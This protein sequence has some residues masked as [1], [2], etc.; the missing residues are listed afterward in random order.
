MDCEYSNTLNQKTK[1]TNML[2][3]EKFYK[4]INDN[5]SL[6]SHG[7]K[8]KYLKSLLGHGLKTI[9]D[10]NEESLWDLTLIPVLHFE[11]FKDFKNPKYLISTL[12]RYFN[13]LNSNEEELKDNSVFKSSKT[14]KRIIDLP[15]KTKTNL[16]IN[17]V[18]NLE[19]V[20]Y[21]YD[22]FH[23]L[24]SFSSYLTKEYLNNCLESAIQNGNLFESYLVEKDYEK[25]KTNRELNIN[26]FDKD[27]KNFID[28][29]K[30]LIAKKLLEHE[31]LYE[32]MLFDT[33]FKINKNIVNNKEFIVSLTNKQIDGLSNLLIRS[34][35]DKESK[36]ILNIKM[37]N[38]LP[39][40][41]DK[42][43][44]PKI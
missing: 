3:A 28:N 25:L 11:D 14:V 21:N 16:I 5:D 43:K 13:M 40:K 24:K 38:S 23:A 18:K 1:N 35:L 8:E 27:F 26:T 6:I 19:F 9:A 42:T 37:E 17:Y 44:Q 22:S 39:I 33:Y 20:E 30:D 29:N 41:N 15:N 32:V 12:A 7:S 34:N 36:I 2:Q 4:F 10:W 31:S